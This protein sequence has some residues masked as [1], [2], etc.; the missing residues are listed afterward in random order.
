MKKIFIKHEVNIIS[1]GPP[2]VG[3][4]F[5][6]ETGHLIYI[7]AGQLYGENG[8]ISNF[9]IGNLLMKKLAI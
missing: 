1:E 7:T 8:R 2:I 9:G 5:Y 3:S 4:C 6:N